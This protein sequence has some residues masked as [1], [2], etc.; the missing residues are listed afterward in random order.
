MTGMTQPH[1]DTP[2]IPLIKENNDGKSD[3]DFV[4]LKLRR[5]PTSP[6]SDLYEFK[7]SL[8]VNG[9]P[10]EFFCSFVTPK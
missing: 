2:F 1:A 9:E 10:E 5:Y 6:M 3:K 8:F 7:M 4:K